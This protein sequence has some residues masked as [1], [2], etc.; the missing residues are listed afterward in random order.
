MDG[1]TFHNQPFPSPSSDVGG[2]MASQM[3]NIF[4]EDPPSSNHILPN[5]CSFNPVSTL[6]FASLVGPFTS[7]FTAKHRPLLISSQSHTAPNPPS[8]SLD[9]FL[10][11]GGFLLSTE[12]FFFFTTCLPEVIPLAPRD[13]GLPVVVRLPKVDL[14]VT[15]ERLEEEL[16]ND[17]IPL[18]RAVKINSLSYAP[19]ALVVVNSFS[20]CGKVVPNLS[21]YFYY[22][23]PFHKQLISV[24]LLEWEN[25]F[26]FC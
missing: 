21:S 22:A 17:D 25:K 15:L 8:P 3:P 10:N 24:S 18:S 13:V 16:P 6:R 23:T 14:P 1:F 2:S 5:H 11:P 12:F 7:C 20:K 26:V 19:R 4:R 9:N